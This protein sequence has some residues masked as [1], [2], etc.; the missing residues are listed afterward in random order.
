M[1]VVVGWLGFR[2]ILGLQVSGRDL[3]AQDPTAPPSLWPPLPQG[4]VGQRG[5]PSLTRSLRGRVV[6]WLGH[7]LQALIPVSSRAPCPTQTHVPALLAGPW[8]LGEEETAPSR[9]KD[10]EPCPGRGAG[11]AA[12][13]CALPAPGTGCL[14]GRQELQRCCL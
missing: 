1:V 8:P 11:A 2:Q 5:L 10:G 13:L 7:S 12:L 14:A 6:G 9:A 3:A 4:E